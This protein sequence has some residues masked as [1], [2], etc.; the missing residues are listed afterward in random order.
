[1]FLSVICNEDVP[2]VTDDDRARMASESFLGDMFE[3]RLK[4]CA[5]WPHSEISD[6]YYEPVKSDLPVLILSG[7]LDPI[8]PPRWGEHIAEHLT[9]ARHVVVPGVGHGAMGQGCVTRLVTQFL[10]EGTAA[11]LDTG[12]I[13]QLRRP[14]FFVSTTGPRSDNP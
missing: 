5:F 10:D 6:D 3:Y 4:P 9:N 14:P 12:C 13:E 1:M 11:N 8:T 7:K 2:R